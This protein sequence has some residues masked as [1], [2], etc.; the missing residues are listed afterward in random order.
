M[1][2]AAVCRGPARCRCPIPA[3]LRSGSTAE[4][5]RP[6]P[7]PVKS[8]ARN[9]PHRFAPLSPLALSG[10]VDSSLEHKKERGDCSPLALR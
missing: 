9:S 4:V 5:A 2:L 7:F 8:A 1:E 10:F 6:R 3:D